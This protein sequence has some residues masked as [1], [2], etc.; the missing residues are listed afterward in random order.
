MVRPLAGTGATE[1]RI[2]RQRGYNNR[3]IQNKA[4]RLCPYLEG[5][6]SRHVVNSKRLRLTLRV[7]SQLPVHSA[8]PS[9]LTPRQL[10]RFSWPVNTPT[11]SP[12][13]VS[14]TL[15]VQS[16]YPPKRIRPE[17]ENA[18]DVMP[19]KILSCVKEL[20]SLSALMSNRRQDASSE[21]VANASPFGKNLGAC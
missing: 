6:R 15:Q 3:G 10:T 14:Q 9:T 8:I 17:I 5:R 11:R 21:P 1:Q 18:T 12:F 2:L 20:S 16:S 7:L 19:H 4:C 13:R